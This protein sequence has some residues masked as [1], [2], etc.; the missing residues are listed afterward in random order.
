MAVN[1]RSLGRSDFL[2]NAGPGQPSAPLRSLSSKASHE[3]SSLKPTSLGVASKRGLPGSQSLGLSRAIYPAGW[4]YWSPEALP[5]DWMSFPQ[6]L[7]NQRWKDGPLCCP[8]RQSVSILA[9][10]PIKITVT[11]MQ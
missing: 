3:H 7:R 4:A 6:G 10:F 1:P 5:G 8:Y 9:L 2:L 11:R